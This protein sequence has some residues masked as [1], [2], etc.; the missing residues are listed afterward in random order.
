MLQ[1]VAELLEGWCEDARNRDSFPPVFLNISDGMSSDSTEEE[2]LAAAER[3]KHIS[4]KDG[5]TL[6]INVNI[7]TNGD[8]A[9]L[10]YPS[11]TDI[12]CCNQHAMLLAKLSSRIPE[13]LERSIQTRRSLLSPPP[14]IAMGY[15]TSPSEFIAM[16]NIGS[17]SDSIRQEQRR[18]ESMAAL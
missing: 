2:L 17:R 4:T 16:F 11:I 6:F 15:N 13:A 5:N 1:C 8:N 9:S 7:S 10:V 18:L 12:D 14:Y 3:I